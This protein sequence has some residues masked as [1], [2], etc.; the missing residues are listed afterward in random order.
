[1][2]NTVII[3]SSASVFSADQHK[4]LAAGSNDFIA[5]P[6]LASELFEKL[7]IY[8]GLEWVYEPKEIEERVDN[9]NV[10]EFVV[11]PKE[12]LETVF[13]AARIGDIE[14][15]Q[16]EANRIKQLDA[17]YKAFGDRLFELAGEFEY[18]PIL[19]LLKERFDEEQDG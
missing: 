3:T 12:E 16:T 7:K 1:M 5:K 10:E 11:P 14:L 15:I 13:K 17:K 4:S 9:S 2:K 8:L 6:V 19:N 18:K